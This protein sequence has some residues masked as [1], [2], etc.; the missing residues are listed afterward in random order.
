M[1]AARA[2]A[3]RTPRPLFHA[4][5]R[6]SRPPAPHCAAPSPPPAATT[7]ILGSPPPC[8]TRR[9]PATSGSSPCL[10]RR[11]P[12]GREAP[13]PL[14]LCR[15]PPPAPACGAPGCHSA[16]APAAAGASRPACRGTPVMAPPGVAAR[17]TAHTRA[18]PHPAARCIHPRAWSMRQ[19]VQLP[20]WR[21]AV[22]QPRPPP[23]S[24]PHAYMHT[25]P[26]PVEWSGPP[27]PAAC[28][29][30]APAHAS[31][32]LLSLFQWRQHRQH[33]AL[34]CPRLAPLPS[35]GVRCRLVD[36]TAAPVRCLAAWLWPELP[37][38]H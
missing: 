18:P 25:S 31:A 15:P 4:A 5:P 20:V 3:G 37:A 35:T 29:R 33:P 10:P 16:H 14:P 11:A 19:R 32:A 24:A 21:T 38:R 12:C 34:P 7:T 30:R 26:T 17:P 2:L 23:P 36:C 22:R 1:R 27:L 28:T 9:P 8:W 6:A 13:P